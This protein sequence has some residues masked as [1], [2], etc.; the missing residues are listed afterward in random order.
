MD[1]NVTAQSG[2]GYTHLWDVSTVEVFDGGFALDKDNL[3][4]TLRVLPRGT[5]LSVDLAE[6][7]AKVV[8][9]AT[10]AEALTTSATEVRIKKGSLLVKGDVIGYGNKSVTVGDIS[11]DA[12]DYDSFSI[13]ANALGAIAVNEVVQSFV[14]TTAVPVAGFNYADVKIDL[15]PS[16]SVIFKVYKVES[17]KLPYPISKAIV[18]ALNLCQIL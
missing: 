3:P 18:S 8:K 10:I 7:T 1:F 14:G 4:A 9:T 13:T 6:R 5:L 2:N 15:Y 16:V 17:D 11:T 12:D